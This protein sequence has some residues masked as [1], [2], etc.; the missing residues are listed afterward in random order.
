MPFFFKLIIFISGAFFCE[1]Y[2][3]FTY[4]KSFIALKQKKFYTQ[5][6]ESAI[7]E[8]IARLL[9]K[10]QNV[11]YKNRLQGHNRY[12]PSDLIALDK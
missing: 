7:N 8:H 4:H 12:E 2:I 3:F 1:V 11:Q 10:K 6:H 9:S 5:K